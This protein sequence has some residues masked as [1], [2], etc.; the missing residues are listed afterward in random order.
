MLD[1]IY[2]ITELATNNIISQEQYNQMEKVYLKLNEIS[3]DIYKNHLWLAQALSDDDIEK[4]YFHLNKAI[5]LSPSSEDVYR[6]I[7]NI[8]FK[9]KR[10]DFLIK[11]YC[12]NYFLSLHGG[13]LDDDRINYLYG[14]N[15]EFVIFLMII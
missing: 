8:Y 7:L 1:E 6:E 10:N 12:Q 5:N 13:N 2:N 9:D 15:N 14:S 4:S 3:D 11:M